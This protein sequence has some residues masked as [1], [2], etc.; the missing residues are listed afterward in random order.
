M[1]LIIPHVTMTPF[2]T[3]Y[4]PTLLHLATHHLHVFGVHR[5]EFAADGKRRNRYFGQI[6]RPVPVDQ[7][8]A[9]LEF[10]RPLHGYIDAL[11]QMFETPQDRFRPGRYTAQM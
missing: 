7:P 10:T 6:L 4:I 8:P 3:I 1:L 9:R 2:R 11:A 5:I